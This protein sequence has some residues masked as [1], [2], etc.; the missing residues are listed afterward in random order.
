MYSKKLPVVKSCF[1]PPQAKKIL[2]YD[3]KLQ[4]EF[5]YNAAAN[6][7]IQSKLLP[8]HF[9]RNGEKRARPMSKLQQQNSNAAINQVVHVVLVTAAAAPSARAES[10]SALKEGGMSLSWTSLFFENPMTTS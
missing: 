2:G 10:S 7:Y 8:I 9:K 6:N 3:H 1:C 5:A 4:M